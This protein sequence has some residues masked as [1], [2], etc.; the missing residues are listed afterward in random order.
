MQHDIVIQLLFELLE[1]KKVTAAYLADKYALS[2]RSVYRYIDYLSPYVPLQVQQGR[3]GGVY[4]SDAYKLPV[5]FMTQEEYEA[6]IGALDI[7][8]GQFAD[9]KYA[10]AKRK[11]SAQAKT[12]ARTLALSGTIGTVLVDG[13]TWG[14]EKKFSDK[15]RLYEECIQNCTVVEIDYNS[16]KGVFSR[17]KI[18]PHVLVFKQGVWYVF[19]FC[20]KQRDFRLFRVGRIFSSVLTGEKFNR[21]PIERDDI[22]LAYWTDENSEEVSLVFTEDGFADALDWLGRENLHEENGAWRANVTLPFDDELVKKLVGFGGR[23]KVL[24][25]AALKDRVQDSAREIL[26]VYS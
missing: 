21:R 6:A 8:Y 17:R 10:A 1:K 13:G 22:P 5:G 2:R 18:E 24:A 9:E 4:I 16:R 20:R 19:A 3:N 23:V 25:P 12:E 11:L 14:D 15:M 26:A 7:A